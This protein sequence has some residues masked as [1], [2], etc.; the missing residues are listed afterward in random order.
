MNRTLP[1]GK[2]SSCLPI[3]LRRSMTVS[4]SNAHHSGTPVKNACLRVVN[5]RVSPSKINSFP[6]M[7]SFILCRVCLKGG[8]AASFDICSGG[9]LACGVALGKESSSSAGIVEFVPNCF[10]KRLGTCSTG[11]GTL[12]SGASPS[13]IG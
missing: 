8:L 4:A 1:L 6:M 2:G 13:T 7:G 9:G 3:G 10:S 5:E 11:S 12:T